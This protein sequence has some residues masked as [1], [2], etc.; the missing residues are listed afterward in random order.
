MFRKLLIAL[1]LVLFLAFGAPRPAQAQWAVIDVGAINQLL[2]EVTLL[3]QQLTTTQEEL[4]QARSTYQAM[5]GDR[6]MER[7]LAGTNRNYLPTDW[8]D[9]QQVMQGGSSS[10]GSLAASVQSL[11]GSNAVLS[12]QQLAALSPTEQA[13][14][15]ADRE[16]VALLQALSRDELSTASARFGSLQE[17]INAIPT[18]TDEKGI[19]DLQARIEVEQAMLENEAIKLSVLNE[20]ERAQRE[21]E[22]EEIREQAVDEIGTLK[23]LPPMGL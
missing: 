5:T 16:H 12:S 22:D 3:R 2:Q 11:V 6:G 20:T 15:E 4:S 18:A 9:L 14:V 19:L 13:D 10:Y 7:L 21:A 8:A 1:P 17:L 23:D